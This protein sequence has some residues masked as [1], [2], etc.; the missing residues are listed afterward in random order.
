MAQFK[1]QDEITLFDGKTTIGWGT[2]S[3]CISDFKNVIFGVF[4][5]GNANCT[6]LPYISLSDNEP[7]WTSAVSPSNRYA[8]IAIWELGAPTLINGTTGITAS[9]T[10]IARYYMVN[11]DAQAWLNFN[12]SAISAGAVTL[13]VKAFTNA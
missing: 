10:D 3:I 6:I 12:I 2:K 13:V 1:F 5:T 9:G 11:T 8:S 7:T 4:T